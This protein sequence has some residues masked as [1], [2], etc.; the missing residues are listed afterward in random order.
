MSNGDGLIRSTKAELTS[1]Q[2]P[3]P[4]TA[5][6]ATGASAGAALVVY[7]VLHSVMWV[8]FA[9]PL[10]VAAVVAALVPL[11]R[12]YPRLALWGG[13]AALG[14]LTLAI[15]LPIWLAFVVTVLAGAGV[16]WAKRS[17]N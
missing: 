12:R 2:V 11:A 17:K 14:A 7:T 10:S 9:W 8:G 1:H 16:A 3:G 4:Q 5:A 6:I 15:A 13:A